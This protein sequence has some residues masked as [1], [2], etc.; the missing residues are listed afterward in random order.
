MCTATIAMALPL[1]WNTTLVQGMGSFGKYPLTS[2][3]AEFINDGASL[4]CSVSKM[5][6]TSVL[7]V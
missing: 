7:L 4:S 5:L 6:L 1:P 2:Y 3:N